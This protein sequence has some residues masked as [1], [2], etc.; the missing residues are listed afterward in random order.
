MKVCNMFVPFPVIMPLISLL[1]V[2]ILQM[3]DAR[4]LT[5]LIVGSCPGGTISNIVVVL[6]NGDVDLR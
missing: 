6:V 3:T 5:L 2:Q 1:F 4:S